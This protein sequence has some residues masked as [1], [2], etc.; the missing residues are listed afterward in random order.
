MLVRQPPR[1]VKFFFGVLYS[2]ESIYIRARELLAEK[3]GTCDFETKPVPF[4]FTDYYQEEMGSGL[5]RRFFSLRT[6]RT[7]ARLV[8]IKLDSIGVEKKFSVGE[9]RKINI[10]PGYIN[11]AKLVLAS[12]KDFSHRIYLSR[13]IFAEVTLTYQHRKFRPLPT[14]FPDYRT[15]WYR[16]QFEQIRTRYR[17]QLLE[18][19][20]EYRRKD[21][22][23]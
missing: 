9:R 16:E 1:P 10:D 18:K 22:P 15:E 4:T 23:A 2:E 12:T 21:H 6:L 19:P 3:Y 5:L 13:G 20:H 11:E 17:E 14:T 8:G 7:P